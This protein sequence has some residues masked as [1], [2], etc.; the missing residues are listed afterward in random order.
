MAIT[1]EEEKEDSDKNDGKSTCLGG[2]TAGT[3]A[4]SSLLC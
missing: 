3:T 1:E 4:P 2:C